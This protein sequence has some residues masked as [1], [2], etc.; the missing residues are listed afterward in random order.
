[1][2]SDFRLTFAWRA[3]SIQFG[4]ATVAAFG[5]GA[6]ARK[7]MAS[8]DTKDDRQDET[9]GIDQE[10]W[11]RFCGAQVGIDVDED[12][13]P[14][15]TLENNFLQDRQA[16][17]LGDF[18]GIKGIATQ[19]ILKGIQDR[20]KQVAPVVLLNRGERLKNA[21][22]AHKQYM[23]SYDRAGTSMSRFDEASGDQRS[24]SI[25]TGHTETR[26]GQTSENMSRTQGLG[27]ST[28]RIGRRLGR[29]GSSIG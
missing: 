28:C 19:D 12:F 15:R 21:Q 13:R 25:P 27:T 17:K 7:P 3:P 10:A 5:G 18:T 14:V 1:M 4:P 23:D 2:T 22:V 29:S 20:R 16:M 26:P 9:K 24:V 11:R 6:T 8:R